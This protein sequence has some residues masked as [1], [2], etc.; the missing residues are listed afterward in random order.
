M[1]P[2]TDTEPFAPPATPFA[3]PPAA[4]A[5]PPTAFVAPPTTLPAAFVTPPTALPAVPA[6]PSIA[7]LAFVFASAPSSAASSAF[8]FAWAFAC[9]TCFFAECLTAFSAASGDAADTSPPA[10]SCALAPAFWPSTSAEPPAE[11]CVATPP[12]C[13]KALVA[14]AATA[15]PI[16]IARILDIAILLNK[17]VGHGAP[18]NRPAAMGS[19]RH[20]ASPCTDQPLSC[21][22]RR[23]R[24]L[25]PT[26]SFADQF[27]TLAYKQRPESREIRTTFDA[28][29][30]PRAPRIAYDAM[31]SPRDA[32]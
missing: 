31:P 30:T 8:A 23:S 16:S 27:D 32:L 21:A 19:P 25:L 26:V 22:V 3:R 1:P 10:F 9:F 24:Q 12:V 20:A 28:R 13:A 2:L 18:S 17:V 11:P 6:A 15:A 5:T 29:L 14:I 7:P 4:P